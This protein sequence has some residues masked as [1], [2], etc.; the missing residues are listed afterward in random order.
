MAAIAG[1]ACR[2][3][4]LPPS[5]SLRVTGATRGRQTPPRLIL[6]LSIEASGQPGH[7]SPKLDDR[8]VRSCAV[9]AELFQLRDFNSRQLGIR[10][11]RHWRDNLGCRG[12]A[13]ALRRFEDPG[14]PSM[15]S[16]KDLV[17]HR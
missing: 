4:K 6:L 17:Q 3:E 13:D 5:T 1:G 11:K 10:L 2:S 12:T 16:I 7:H 15:L 8:S 14:S 9:A